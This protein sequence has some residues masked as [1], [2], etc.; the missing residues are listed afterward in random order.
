MKKRKKKTPPPKQ[1]LK[2]LNSI[3]NSL[4]NYFPIAFIILVFFIIYSQVSSFDIV[5][6]DDYVV[7]KNNPDIQSLNNIGKFFTS[8]YNGN[9]H[10]LTTLS[11]AIN[12]YFGKLNGTGYHLTNI[13]LH[14]INIFLVYLFI[15]K[16]FNRNDIS[17]FVAALFAIHPMHVES[18][19][20]ISE[21]KD[22]LYAFFFLLSLNAYIHFIHKEKKYFYWFS[23]LFFALSLLSKS[24]AIILPLVLLL[25]DYFKNIPFN[26]KNIFSKIPF[27]L[28]SIIFGIIA[29]KSQ[30]TA[31]E[32]GFAPHFSWFSRI[33][34]AS[35]GI[36]YYIL[37]LFFPFHQSPLHPYPIN[38]NDTLPVYFY[39]SVLIILLFFFLIYFLKNHRKILIFGIGFFLI[40]LALVIQLLPVGKAIVAERYT[41]LP[42]IGLYSL[43]GYFLF[44]SNKK[45]KK[46]LL[47]GAFAWM[48]FLAF[49][50]Y[51]RLPVWKN[52][53]A[54][55]SDII[56][57]YPKEESAYYNR[58]LTKYYLENYKGAFRDYS[59]AIQLKPDNAVALYNRS[60][61]YKQWQDYN[62]IL[63]DLNKAISISPDYMDA[64]KNRGI[65][66]AM[67]K[68]Y[69]NAVKDF[70][71]ILQKNPNDTTVLLNRGITYLNM[72]NPSGACADFSEAMGLGCKSASVIFSAN[73]KNHSK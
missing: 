13:F 52:S 64:R 7:I 16:L 61:I 67:L 68:N 38:E 37:N 51:T 72:N 17:L 39:S 46:I 26:Y 28:L 58:G 4:I 9:Y 47:T 31:M 55:F 69:D 11:W 73:C 12:F 30:H 3:K 14:A 35:Y 5:D 56:E 24:A 71:Y 21:R 49:K 66:Q 10:P 45:T 22:V 44:N 48:L 63:F 23:L 27:F 41:Y 20:W 42:Y 40:N 1:Q 32:Y 65:A 18:I 53:I 43:L 60:L 70:N 54:L 59:K 29:I 25:I 33:F 62:G 15:K 2:K 57:K 6:W 34:I 19:A 50:T 36:V 8:F